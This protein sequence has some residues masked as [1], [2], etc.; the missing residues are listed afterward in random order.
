MSTTGRRS[1]TSSCCGPA[2]RWGSGWFTPGQGSPK[3]A[4]RSNGSSGPCGIRFLV[5][6]GSGRELDDLV[7]LNTLFTAWVE[8]VY[9]RRDHSETEQTPWDRWSTIT[10][11]LP[12][13]TQLREA[14]LWSEWRTVTKTATVSLHGNTYQVDAAL[15][16]RKVELVFDPFDLTD[17][18]VR[19]QGRAMGH[20]VPHRIGRHVHH[21]ARPDEATPATAAPTGINYLALV[22][23]QHTKE[24]SERLRYCQLPDGPLP[25]QQPLPGITDPDP[26]QTH[27]DDHTSDEV[28]A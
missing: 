14:F 15:I 10:P 20:A 3:D 18:E 24:I 28:P 1:S 19:W 7:Q 17:I 9:H 4:E 23:A 8:T 16:G 12:T 21:K 27:D 2:R 26:D 25:G 22:E 6:I 11:T 13:P 5:E